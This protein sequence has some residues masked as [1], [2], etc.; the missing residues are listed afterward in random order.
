MRSLPFACLAALVTA[1][2][3]TACQDLDGDGQWDCIG[4]ECDTGEPG[5]PR[6]LSVQGTRG[7][8][9]LGGVMTLEATSAS[10]ADITLQATPEV[11]VNVTGGGLGYKRVEL[12]GAREGDGVV[13]FTTSTETLATSIRVKQA[14]RLAIGFAALPE[15]ANE[16]FVVPAGSTPTDRALALT[17]F[18]ADG[19]ILHDDSLALASDSSPEVTR[20]SANRLLLPAAPGTY[21][22]VFESGA[23]GRQPRPIQI[24]DHIDAIVAERVDGDAMRGRVCLYGIAGDELATGAWR[25]VPTSATTYVVGTHANCFAYE[26]QREHAQVEVTLAG[27]TQTF[28]L[29]AL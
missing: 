13:T 25:Y 5:T 16:V 26:A 2:S 9:A 17:L 12:T 20:S 1:G 19:T 6:D 4:Q 15:G 11:M 8:V 3:L 10:A 7:N 18:A 14:T 29:A 28:D 27:V 22:V 21:D 23:L 24:V